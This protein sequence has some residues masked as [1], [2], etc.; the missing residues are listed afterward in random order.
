MNTKKL[1]IAIMGTG[2][3]IILSPFELVSLR[4]YRGR[5]SETLRNT[6]AR[7]KSRRDGIAAELKAVKDSRLAVATLS[8]QRRVSLP[9]VVSA[10][11]A[12]SKERS[13]VQR[14]SVR[15]AIA[16]HAACEVPRAGTKQAGA[17]GWCGASSIER[18]IWR[19][20]E[21]FAVKI[22]SI[23]NERGQDA[24]SGVRE[25][26]FTEIPFLLET[27]RRGAGRSEFCEVLRF[28]R[29]RIKL[30]TSRY[31]SALRDERRRQSLREMEQGETSMDEWQDRDEFS[32]GAVSPWSVLQLVTAEERG[33]SLPLLVSSDPRSLH[34]GKPGKRAEVLE[35]GAGAVA[36]AMFE[37]AE[38]AARSTGKGAGSRIKGAVALIKTADC[39]AIALAGGCLAPED[40][41]G[42]SSGANGG[43][44]DAWRQ[45]IKRFKD[46]TA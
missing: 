29:A 23:K 41:A 35:T 16:A 30:E 46:L 33:I 27:V 37:S 43:I 3:G 40:A 31:F 14:K 22:A 39:V 32:G 5:K 44:G 18:A 36:R 6:R 11:I 8:S 9:P 13:K 28:V 2:A 1:K 12:E 15:D 26:V 17:G 19:G 10:R 20:A 38:L 42:L 24:L 7:D 34:R 25:I 4:E 45:R 21:R